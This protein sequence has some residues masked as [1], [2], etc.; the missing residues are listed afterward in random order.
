MNQ[1]SLLTNLYNNANNLCEGFLNFDTLDQFVFL[2]SN[3]QYQ[4]IRSIDK[5]YSRRCDKLYIK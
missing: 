5:A 3:M 4:V 1:S 2:L